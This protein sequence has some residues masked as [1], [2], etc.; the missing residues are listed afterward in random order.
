MHVNKVQ[1]SRAG[2]KC[3][4]VDFFVD[5][6]HPQHMLGSKVNWVTRASCFYTILCND[7]LLNG[8]SCDQPSAKA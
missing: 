1:Y 6:L 7:F 8:G 4:L 3:M 5:Q 2:H